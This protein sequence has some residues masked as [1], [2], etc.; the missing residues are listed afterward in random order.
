MAQVT[1]SGTHGLRPDG[2]RS[3]DFAEEAGQAWRNSQEFTF[4]KPTYMLAMVPRV[5]RPDL[6]VEIEIEIV[7]AVAPGSAT[8]GQDE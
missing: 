4:H 7:A 5:L 1:L 8:T 3:D 2:S 6:R